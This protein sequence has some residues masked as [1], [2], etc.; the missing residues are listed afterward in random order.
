MAGCYT[1]FMAT[2]RYIA[3][4][5]GINVGG[6][7]LIKMAALRECLELAGLQ[8]VSTYIASGNVLFESSKGLETVETLFDATVDD[9]FGY[10]G[11]TVIVSEQDYRTIVSEAPDAFGSEPDRL[12]SDVIFLKL[13]VDPS[14]ILQDVLALSIR[15][16]VDTA[17]AGS[18][19]LYF[20]RVSDLRT[21]S[22]MSKITGL[23]SYKSM[24]IRSWNTV[25]KLENLLDA[26][27]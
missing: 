4:L 20:T 23:S 27:Q 1:V 25:K 13:P 11:P 12:H 10:K 21:K 2:T 14:S 24:T 8:Y 9:T 5:R 7:N 6:N 15:E 16:G 22:R 17:T 18:K 19:A 3:L 26:K